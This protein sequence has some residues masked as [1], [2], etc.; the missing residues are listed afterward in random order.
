MVMKKTH[1]SIGAGL[2]AASLAA[3]LQSVA[4]EAT[5]IG[6]YENCQ[7]VS[8]TIIVSDQIEQAHRIVAQAE[9]AGIGRAFDQAL[10]RMIA[11]L[12]GNGVKDINEQSLA[13][14]LLLNPKPN[15][16]IIG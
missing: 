12:E 14:F 10:P 9:A 6:V 7:P 3:P 4:N 15:I 8:S 16:I 1:Y 2:L 13:L 11:S 5:I